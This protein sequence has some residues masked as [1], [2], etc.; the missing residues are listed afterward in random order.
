MN[1][2]FLVV[3]HD[4]KNTIH[5]KNITNRVF[6]CSL[7][8]A[9]MRQQV[10]GWVK[11]PE[12]LC[13]KNRLKR[14]RFFCPPMLDTRIS[15]E[16][17]A[18]MQAGASQTQRASHT[19]MYTSHT[20]PLYK[21]TKRLFI[22]IPQLGKCPAQTTTSTTTTTFTSNEPLKKLR[23]RLRNKMT[24]EEHEQEYRECLQYA[25]VAAP[26]ATTTSGSISMFNRL[27]PR[28]DFSN[29]RT[30]GVLVIPPTITT[31]SISSIVRS[32]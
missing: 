25:M 10:W 26:Y 16:C 5:D 6:F 1:C 13:P 30:F 28:C 4:I 22:K 15:R 3:I 24:Q 9:L 31:S 12:N 8:V 7:G 2:V 17:S 32:K 14:F 29:S 21:A 18:R 23:A 11:P 27:T 20:T 19:Y